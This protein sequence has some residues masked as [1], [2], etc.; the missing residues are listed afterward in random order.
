M[1]F[2]HVLMHICV[3]LQVGVNSLGVPYV[4][5]ILRPAGHVNKYRRLVLV[6]VKLF[7]FFSTDIIFKIVRVLMTVGGHIFETLRSTPSG[8]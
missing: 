8:S 4:P 3:L 7:S 1:L 5:A 2:L 6:E